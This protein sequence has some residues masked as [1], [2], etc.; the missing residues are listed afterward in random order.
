VLHLGIDEH[1]RFFET[2]AAAAPMGAITLR[3]AL[4]EYSTAAELSRSGPISAVPLL[5]Y[6]YTR[7]GGFIEDS[8]APSALAAIV[9][10]LPADRPERAD[11]LVSYGDQAPGVKVALRRWRTGQRDG[12]DFDWMA[13]VRTLWSEY[14]R[15]LRRFHH[16]GFYRHNAN[17]RNLGLAS[18]G[19]FLVDLDSTRHLLD[20]PPQTRALQVL[21]D[22]SGGLFHITTSIVDSP[23]HNLY[24][25]G[26]IVAGGL[27][28]DYLRA[29]FP[30]LP[31]DAFADVNATAE[32]IL[33][34]VWKDRRARADDDLA[35]ENPLSA[36]YQ[37]FM[38]RRDWLRT[39]A[40]DRP[41]IFCSL[42]PDLAM[43]Y[44]QSASGRL[45]PLHASPAELRALASRPR[46]ARPS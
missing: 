32:T 17:P 40:I 30:D 42:I 39:R 41:A 16:C 23:L 46:P 34:Q 8:G 13:A 12:V 35:T 7:M 22:V 28:V 15:V 19:I 45:H 3:R 44:A 20:S 14:G 27:L 31:A 11:C 25:P 1:G 2:P 33:T 6:Q 4:V 43:P 18:Q 10:G 26:E 36:E 21:R 9:V 29:Y 38:T 5:L 24:T 37:Q